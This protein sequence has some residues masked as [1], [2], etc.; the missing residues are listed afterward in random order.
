[1]VSDVRFVE[2]EGSLA[3]VKPKAHVVV[4]SVFQRL[5]Y[6]LIDSLSQKSA[7]CRPIQMKR[8]LLQH[9]KFEETELKELNYIRVEKPK[10]IVAR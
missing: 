2:P 7:I 3:H 9:V 10:D 8:K 4:S 6:D 1:M 5:W